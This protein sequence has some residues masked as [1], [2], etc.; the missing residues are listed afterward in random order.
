MRA[1]FVNF[2]FLTAFIALLITV[3]FAVSLIWNINNEYRMAYQL[4]KIEVVASFNKDMVFRKWVSGHGGVYVPLTDETQANPNLSDVPERDIITDSGVVLT[5]MNPAYVMRQ[6]HELGQE[7]YG[8]P[9][10]LISLSGDYRETIPDGWE[11]NALEK[12][13]NNPELINEIDKTGDEGFIRVL[14]PVY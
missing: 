3:L 6:I 10:H 5:L 14:K 2:K 8:T 4:A 12:L 7:Q 9:G 11:Q 13:K 1:K